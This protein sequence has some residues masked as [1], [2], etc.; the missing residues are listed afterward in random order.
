MY[1]NVDTTAM[2]I[3][4]TCLS[5]ESWQGIIAHLQPGILNMQTDVKGTARENL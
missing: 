1:I 2:C 3:T 4:R 5:S